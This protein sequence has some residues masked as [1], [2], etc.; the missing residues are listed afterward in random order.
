MISEEAFVAIAK[1]YY[2]QIH[3]AASEQQDFYSYEKGI[4]SVMGKMTA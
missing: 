2:S 4:V 1:K 3:V